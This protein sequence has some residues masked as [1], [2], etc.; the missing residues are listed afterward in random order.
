MTRI[1]RPRESLSIA[2]VQT[3]FLMRL[4][5]LRRLVGEQ[6]FD[7]LDQK[8]IAAGLVDGRVVARARPIKLFLSR[9]S[10]D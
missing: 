7:V 1:F 3:A 8:P 10:F 4:E 5:E 6:V 9:D 2:F